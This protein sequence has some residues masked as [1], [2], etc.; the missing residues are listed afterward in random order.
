MTILFKT[1]A[2]TSRTS[3]GTDVIT[4]VGFTPKIILFF[5]TADFNTDDTFAADYNFRFGAAVD[6]TSTNQGSM[7]SFSLDGQAGVSAADRAWYGSGA[8]VR[9]VGASPTATASVSAIGSDGFTINW[10][11]VDG[12]SHRIHY[13][14][15]GGTDITNV[16]SGILSAPTATGNQSYTGPGFKPDFLMLW[17]NEINSNGPTGATFGMGF[18]TSATSQVSLSGATKDN[19]SPHVSKR[20]Q[21]S[22]NVICLVELDAFTPTAGGLGGSLVSMDTTGFTINWSNVVT[23]AQ[24]TKVGYLA[25]K[26]GGWKVGSETS[27]TSTG[28][29]ATTGVGFQPNG[30]I[31][32]SVCNTNSTAISANNRIC[33]GGGSSSSDNRCVFTGETD[34]AGTTTTAS[35]QKASKCVSVIV[36]AGTHTSSTVSAEAAISTLDSNGF[37]LNWSTA[38]A[39]AFEFL[40]VAVGSGA[41]PQNITKTLTESI[42]IAGPVPTTT[43]NKLVTKTLTESIVIGSPT[44]TRPRGKLRSPSA[45]SISLAGTVDTLILTSSGKK[46]LSRA[47]SEFMTIPG[48]MTYVRTGRRDVIKTLTEFLHI[49]DSANYIGKTKHTGDPGYWLPLKPRIKIYAFTDS[50]YSTPLYTYDAFTDGSGG[51]DKPIAL[52]FESS[53]TTAGTFSLQIDNSADTYDLDQFARGN[54][55][56]IDC[57]KDGVVWSSAFRGLVRSVKQKV[58]GPDNR[59]IYIEGFSYVIRLNERVL[60]TKKQAALIGP[61]YDRTDTT[62]FTDN[63]INN[64]LTVDT[65]YV[66]TVDDTQLYSVF[67]T[68]NITSSPIEDWIPRLDVQLTSV[69]QAIN[70]IL[71]YSQSFLT[72]D[73]TNDQIVLFNPDRVPSGGANAFLV[74]DAV[75][76][77]ADSSQNT[78]YPMNDYSYE[79]SYD[80]ADSANR[81]ISAIGSVECPTATVPGAVGP[82]GSALYTNTVDDTATVGA[83]LYDDWAV[84]TG[85]GSGPGAGPPTNTAF[86]IGLASGA[87]EIGKILGQIDVAFRNVNSVSGTIRV[88]IWNAS[89]QAFTELGTVDAA[90]IPNDGAYHGFGLSDTGNRHVCVLNDHVGVDCAGLTSPGIAVGMNTGSSSIHPTH[91]LA[92]GPSWQVTGGSWANMTIKTYQLDVSA[93]SIQMN[94]TTVQRVAILINA[95]NPLIGHNIGRISLSLRRSVATPN[96]QNWVGI[97]KADNTFI[98]FGGGIFDAS[99]FPYFSVYGMTDYD[100]LENHYQLAIGDRICIEGNM[101]TGYI[102]IQC[103]TDSPA[104]QT[105]QIW[106]GSA[107]TTS[108]IVGYNLGVVLYQSTA[109]PDV[110]VDPCGGLPETRDADPLL[111]IAS[112]RNMAKRI[113][114]VEQVISNIPPH[115]KTFQSMNE[116]MFNKLY[117]MSRPRFTFDYPSLTL[118]SVMPKAGDITVHVSKKA[119]IGKAR[120]PVQTGII[121]QVTYDFGQDSDSILGLRRLSLETNGI[122]RGSY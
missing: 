58:F 122:L 74:T 71:E 26:G 61:N 82:I 50:T 4:G 67:K 92:P 96:N 19:T 85:L 97:R 116:Y 52:Q 121:T 28:T 6:T 49:A 64:L 111:T 113:G 30:L 109:Q 86:A 1:G 15:I 32:A 39:S 33:F 3:T 100:K 98:Y 119:N 105:V 37:T 115:V 41:A 89:G 7:A 69:D 2:W 104:Y 9:E 17:G 38:S 65:N 99:T 5:W 79:I 106:N 76:L 81:L 24:S 51:I 103:S 14:C 66:K 20:Y 13:I 112:D 36:E 54:R 59:I 83:V 73:V 23:A 12:S 77:Q 10:S 117:I 90:T 8:L 80:F 22:D 63:L 107:W 44:P 110:I 40:Y 114:M 47:L 56:T 42:A 93:N 34:A 27:K 84:V 68:S 87:T 101:T 78:M 91:H 16:K 62:M 88:G 43:K 31:I 53:T 48:S 29:K 35:I 21:R 25:V 46:K 108:G 57:S 95:G 45:E 94:G 60:S 18:A 11:A 70:S 102:E 75:N 120:T 55:I 72:V 118:P